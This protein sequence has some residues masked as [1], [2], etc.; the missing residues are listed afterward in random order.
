MP[1]RVHRAYL[2]ALS[3]ND[4]DD[5][6]DGAKNA[7]FCLLFFLRL[8]LHLHRT[9]ESRGTILEWLRP[10]QRRTTRPLPAAAVRAAQLPRGRAI[11]PPLL[12][13]TANSPVSFRS[14]TSSRY[15]A[16]LIDQTFLQAYFFKKQSFS[17]S[18]FFLLFLD[19]SRHT[20]EITILL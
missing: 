5:D 9:D 16:M 14:I 3:R 10:V 15:T 6:D 13:E 17:Y 2:C 18:F 11:L 19:T 1:S 12:V 7:I 20:W 8:Q 4:D